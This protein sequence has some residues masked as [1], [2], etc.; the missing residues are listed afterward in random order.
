MAAVADAGMA[1]R[2]LPVLRLMRA[3][4]L[5]PVSSD[6]AIANLDYAMRSMSDR[7]HLVTV[8]FERPTWTVDFPDYMRIGRLM[9][10]Q[11][12]FEVGASWELTLD[13]VVAQIAAKV[14]ELCGHDEGG[15]EEPISSFGL[16][17]ISVAE[18]GTFIQTQFNYRA[19]ALELMTTASALSL[20]QD[21]IH[22]KKDIEEDQAETVAA[23]PEDALLVVQRHGHRTPS[24]FASQPEAHFPRGNDGPSSPLTEIDTNGPALHPSH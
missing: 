20:A 11:D 4:G 8:L 7:D 1:T 9:N 2:N 12:A 21:I 13:S 18:L 22:G 19:S 15:V 23:G 24:A 10:N 14:A 3:A 17:S 6:F 16:T 5:P